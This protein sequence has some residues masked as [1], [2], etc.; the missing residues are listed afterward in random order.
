MD[1]ATERY[2]SRREDGGVIREQNSRP[3]YSVEGF[4]LL[5]NQHIRCA[6]K[7][8]AEVKGQ[9][10]AYLGSIVSVLLPSSKPQANYYTYIYRNANMGQSRI[11]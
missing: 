1:M 5:C 6:V 3:I 2:I 4:V 10:P 11:G 9:A 7:R 8:R